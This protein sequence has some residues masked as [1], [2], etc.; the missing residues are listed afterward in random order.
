MSAV[1]GARTVADV[2]HGYRQRSN[3]SEVRDDMRG[4]L[5]RGNSRN[6]IL[7]RPNRAVVTNGMD[8]HVLHEL[9]R[10]R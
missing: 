6:G 5:D 7:P 10:V 3:V 2:A 1:C 9:C 8:E 4:T